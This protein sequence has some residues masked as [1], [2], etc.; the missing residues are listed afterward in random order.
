MLFWNLLL[1]LHIR[2]ASGENV[3]GGSFVWRN[4]TPC[5]EADVVAVLVIIHTRTHIHTCT[6]ARAHTHVHSYMY[7]HTYTHPHTHVHSRRTKRKFGDERFHFFMVLVGIQ[8][9]INAAF[10]KISKLGSPCTGVC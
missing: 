9:V 1:L 10:A 4:V 8:C 7:T 6:H 3:S 5:T 2:T